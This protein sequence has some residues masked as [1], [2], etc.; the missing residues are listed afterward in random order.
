KGAQEVSAAWLRQF[1]RVTIYG[2]EELL[3]DAALKEQIAFWDRYSQ[4]FGNRAI[5]SLFAPGCAGSQAILL[6][7]LGL[8]DGWGGSR[9]LPFLLDRSRLGGG[10]GAHYLVNAWRPVAGTAI[11]TSLLSIAAAMYGG[12]TWLNRTTAQL[13]PESRMFYSHNISMTPVDAVLIEEA[14]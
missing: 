12:N 6:E 10:L 1:N 4:G 3:S 9:C 5:N 8:Y 11:Q 13:R 14:D 2:G 7:R